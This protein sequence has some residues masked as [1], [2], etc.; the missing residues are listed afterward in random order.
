L[1]T[2]TFEFLLIGGKVCIHS[3]PGMHQCYVGLSPQA[4]CILRL[5]TEQ[6]ASGYGR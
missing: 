1:L 2:N 6:M 4:Q 5:W 3:Q